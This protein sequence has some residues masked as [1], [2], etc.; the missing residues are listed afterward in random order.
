MSKNKVSLYSGIFFLVYGL[1][2]FGMASKIENTG[3][4]SLGAGF[5]P[6]L[7]SVVIVILSI[8]VIAGAVVSLKIEKKSGE[9]ETK[10]PSVDVKGVIAT[11]VLLAAY[12]ILLKPVGF[13]I[14]SIIYMFLQMYLLAPQIT[15]KK[16]ILY[17]VISIVTPFIVNYIFIK[18]FTLMLPSGILG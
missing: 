3:I 6:T 1:S 17:A 2:M 4:T 5:V 15:K 7:V 12:A 11:I 18:F 13:I 10:K 9:Q 8:I 14:A 16:L